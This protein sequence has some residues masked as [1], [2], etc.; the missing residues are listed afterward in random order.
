MK[1]ILGLDTGTNSVGWA[2]IERDMD[3]YQGKILG[4]GSRIIPMDQKEIGDFNKG[5][6]ESAAAARTH[7]RGVRRLKDRQLK[8]RERLVRVLK[9]AGFI[10]NE[11]MPNHKSSY[12]YELIN[13]QYQFKFKSAYEEM[14]NI[15]LEKHPKLKSIPYDWTVYYLRVKA[16]TEKISKQELVWVILHFNTKRGYFQLRGDDALDTNAQQSFV[17]SIVDDIEDLNDDVRGK[18]SLKITLRDDIV[19]LY[20]NK[21]I[22]DWIG[23]QIEFIVTE[24]LVKG[25]V[26]V[27]LANPD[28]NDW[29]LRKKKTEQ[30]IENG[31][32]TVAEYIFQKLLQDPKTK[33]RGKEVHTIDR[34]FYKD[35]FNRILNQQIEYHEELNDKK[36]LE[37]AINELYKHNIGHRENL[38]K[39]NLQHLL[40][41]DIMYYQRPLKTKK[42]LI[43]NCKYEYY[44]IKM[45]NGDVSKKNVKAAAKSHPLYQEYRIWSLIHNLRVIEREQKDKDGILRQDIDITSEVLD[46]TRKLLL[47]NTFNSSAELSENQILKAIGLNSTNHK[48]NYEEG[49]K[50]KGNETRAAFLK[51]AKKHKV[52]KEMKSLLAIPEMLNRLWHAVYSLGDYDDQL[53]SALQNKKLG[54]PSDLITVILDVP[55]FKKE[56]AS[57]SVKA[58]KKIVP[59]MRV[60]SMWTVQNVHENILQRINKIVNAEY[61]N[62]ISDRVRAQLAHIKSVND[63]NGMPEYMA[64]YLAYGRHS[65]TIDLARYE[66]PDDIDVNKLIPNHSL[67]NPTAEKIIR[68]TLQ[69]VKAVWKK[70]GRPDEIH[71]EMAR[72]LKSSGDERKKITDRRNQNYASNQRAKAMLRELHQDQSN[73]NPHSKGHIEIFKIYEEGAAVNQKDIDKDIQVIRRKGDPT[74]TEL[75]RYKLWLEQKYL[76]PYTGNPIPLSKLFSPAYEIEHIIPRSIYYD[77]SFNNKVIC[78][79]VANSEKDNATAYKFICDRG[80]ETLSDGSTLLTKDQYEEQIRRMYAINRS[81]YKNLMSY[82]PPAGFTQRQLNNTRYINKKLLSLLNPIVKEA[83]EQEASSKH[84]LSM[85]GG[86]TNELKNDWG[87][88]DVWKRILAPRF[89]RMNEMTGTTDYYRKEGNKI[90]L[91]GYQNELKRLDH[92]HHALD[93]LV[94]ACTTRSHIQYKNS[95]RSNNRL[96]NLESK[97]LKTDPNG[98]RGKSYKLPWKSIAQDT[99]DTLSQVI[100]SFKQ[101]KRV[102]T[103]TINYYQKYVQQSDG[104]W[105]KKYVKQATHPQHW[106]VRKS[107]HKDTV[108]GQ[109]TLREYKKVSVNLAIKNIDSIADKTIKLELREMLSKLGGNIDELKKYLKKNP[110][111]REDKNLS[112]IHIIHYNSDYSTSKMKIDES[113]TVKQLHKIVD[114]DLKWQ[115][116]NQLE[117]HDMDAEKAFSVNGMIKFNEGRNTPVYQVK[118]KEVLGLK[119]NLV[120]SDSKGVKFVEADKGTNLFFEIGIDDETKEHIID[121]NS[122]ISFIDVLDHQVKGEN[123]I[124]EGSRFYLSP[125][126]LVKLKNDNSIGQI[127]RC[128]SFS[129]ADCFFLPVNVS[130][131]IVDKSEY[132][133]LNKRERSLD[134]RMIKRECSVIY[135]DKLGYEVN[136]I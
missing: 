15:F 38:L 31:N 66:T 93:A 67:R 34:V 2:M 52:I 39:L 4:M 10:N 114:E 45:K 58:L 92:R 12:A 84:L 23:K 120:K 115:L 75:I 74:K 73:I 127:Y 5:N 109:V 54:I 132:S 21:E 32:V 35:E 22:P 13:G 133:K 100:A 76:S 30:Q 80:G 49:T 105:K 107:L 64:V 19:G 55:T 125:G 20:T 102:A 62:N 130:V 103:K 65:E 116:L 134:E 29:T 70:F 78:E 94:V 83:H 112:K 124:N 77:D 16:L 101:N 24:K 90:H 82:D 119:K 122:T 71:L 59:L 11:W 26:K 53:K 14:L 50:L 89:I 68:E 41:N 51:I 87:L 131:P 47:F 8:R 97:L 129:K 61:D 86:I 81:K 3:A 85:A 99:Y 118:V 96:Y 46:S 123:L 128:I 27:T 25:E 88:H 1:R 106:A 44:Y 63:C 117:A 17:S 18:K 108:Y 113:V 28:P 57:Y 43:A 136:I 95:L 135:I 110:I 36:V 37:D 33:I 40:V 9:C 104:T 69:V 111:Q 42:H 91:S 126:S 79:R 56:Y 6:L 60:D 7:Y 48:F 121:R 72:E 98:R